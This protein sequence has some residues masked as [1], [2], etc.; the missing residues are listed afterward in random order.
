MSRLSATC[1]QHLEAMEDPPVSARFLAEL[2]E[3]CERG[4]RE[5]ESHRRAA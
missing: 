2:R 4:H 1:V 3:L 5:L